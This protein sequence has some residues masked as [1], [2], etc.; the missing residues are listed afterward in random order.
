MVIVIKF[1]VNVMGI[2]KENK[3]SQNFEK[4]QHEE[5]IKYMQK[6]ENKKRNIKD[7]VKGVIATGLVVGTLV[8]GTACGIN[9]PN[10]PVDPNDPA[11][12]TADP[13]QTTA[14][15][16]QT[17]AD[18]AQTTADP[19]Q[20]TADPAQTTADP[21]QTTVPV[22]PVD[23]PQHNE[24]LQRFN[25]AIEFA[26]Q[27]AE[28]Q[29]IDFVLL[30]VI[31]KNNEKSYA[32]SLFHTNYDE[33]GKEISSKMVTSNRV[34]PENFEVVCNS[35]GMKVE[36]VTKLS[37]KVSDA[38]YLSNEALDVISAPVLE[39]KIKF[40]SVQKFNATLSL[41]NKKYHKLVGKISITKRI[42]SQENQDYEYLFTLIADDESQI[43]G[44]YYISQQDF[45]Y[46]ADVIVFENGLYTSID[47]LNNIADTNCLNILAQAIE[48]QEMD[49]E[50]SK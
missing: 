40:E 23:P 11:Q 6:V 7:F 13:A 28:G 5:Y 43:L 50:Q 33:Q 36:Q 39:S 4:D 25:E 29:S 14:D 20:T 16:A 15:P 21:A 44:T 45:E 48:Q 17:T 12:T 47:L 49:Q 19:A 9:R 18:P 10:N 2:H 42:I 24:S 30:Q 3:N 32:I 41:I 35:L 37:F 26:S 27:S 46:L 34:S 38:E 31:S 1:G 8:T 22:T